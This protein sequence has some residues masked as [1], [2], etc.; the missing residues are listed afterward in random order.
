MRDW[1]ATAWMTGFLAVLISYS[2]PLLIFIQAAQAGG[3]SAEMLSSWIWGI[4]IGAGISGIILSLWLKIPVITAWSSPG[5]A[6]LLHVIPALSM[7]EVVGAYLGAALITIIIGVGGYFEKIVQYIPRSMAAA[8]MAGIL[9]QFGIQ[10]FAASTELPMVVL[11]MLAAYVLCRR[12]IPTFTVILVAVVGFV[13]V[14]WLGLT[15]LQQ[16]SVT[17]ATPIFT[18]PEFNLAA[19]FSLTVPLVVVSL[20]G[21]YLPGLFVLRLEGYQVPSRA[22]VSGTGLVSLFVAFFGGISIVLSSI[23]AAICSGKDSHPDPK[24]RYVA[25]VA[26]GVFYLVGGVFAGTIVLLFSAIPPAL[27]AALAGLALIG[28]IVSNIQSLAAE[29]AHVEPAVI[30]FLITAS[31]MT[32]AG[33][34]SA[35][36][37]IV[38]GMGAYWV[39]GY[40]RSLSTSKS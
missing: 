24:K 26:N 1:S 28:A 17:L 29:P 3:M 11:L 4:S 35:F 15:Q 32:I 37:G 6:L 34:G 9:F 8:M 2:G 40:K 25:G 31:N 5:T 16:V 38:L 10:A 14:Y 23:T 27:V 18:W 7:A 22:I 33:M 30:T 19:F 20:S 36:W 39:L 13:S 21:Q 12:F